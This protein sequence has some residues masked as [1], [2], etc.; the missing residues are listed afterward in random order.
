MEWLFKPPVLQCSSEHWGKLAMSLKTQ[1]QHMS[2]EFIL[3]C[4]LE[5]G[6]AV[7][8]SHI[9]NCGGNWNI[10]YKH[11]SVISNFES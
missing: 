7:G 1:D 8:K 10:K 9:T 6:V 5:M 4:S 2:G 3:F 11:Y